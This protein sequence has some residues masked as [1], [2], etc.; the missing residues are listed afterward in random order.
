M[1]ALWRECRG[2]VG[3]ERVECGGEDV[4]AVQI[5][6]RVPFEF[7]PILATCDGGGIVRALDLHLVDEIDF[8][9][10]LAVLGERIFYDAEEAARLEAE[11]KAAEEAAAAAANPP[12]EP[13]AEEAPKP[14]VKPVFK[15][16]D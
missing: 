2:R 13:A 5:L 6:Q 1:S 9:V 10:R 8:G 16:F 4:R 14:S 15:R 7:Y 12:A 11:K 3:G